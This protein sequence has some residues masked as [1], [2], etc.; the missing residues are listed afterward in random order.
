[1]MRICCD[2]HRVGQGG[3]WYDGLIMAEYER[4][5]PG[6]CPDCA[7]GVMAEVEEFCGATARRAETAASR[8]VARE[9]ML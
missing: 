5:P 1:M 7:A 3:E 2:C 4:L 6:Y 9:R 8:S